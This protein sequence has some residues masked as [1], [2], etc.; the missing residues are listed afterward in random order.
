M[1]S[2]EWGKLSPRERD[3]L[4]AQTLFGI[5]PH[6]C[7][8]VDVFTIDREWLDMGDY[9]YYIKGEGHYRIDDYTT[10]N[11][12]SRLV[13]AAIERR[14]LKCSYATELLAILDHYTMRGDYNEYWD[15]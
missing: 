11:N 13:E 2:E 5:M 1:T 4:I 15:L 12:A 14:E 6:R 9:S 7:G 3:A 10:D 8:E